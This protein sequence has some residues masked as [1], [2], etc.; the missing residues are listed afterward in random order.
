MIDED[1]WSGYILGRQGGSM[2]GPSWAHSV[3]YKIGHQAGMRV[4]QSLAH[5]RI[6]S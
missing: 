4:Y 1:W 3:P 6:T 2:T 5:Q